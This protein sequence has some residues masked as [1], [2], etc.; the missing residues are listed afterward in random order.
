[1]ARSW[2][3][4]IHISTDSMTNWPS[5]KIKRCDIIHYIIVIYSIAIHGIY[6][7][8]PAKSIETARFREFQCSVV[9]P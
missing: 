5:S 1:M 2:K 6:G 8:C 4:I 9:I 7:K 3:I